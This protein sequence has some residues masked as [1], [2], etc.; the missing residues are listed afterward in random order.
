[1]TVVI[2]L[3]AKD[4]DKGV[5]LP[6]PFGIYNHLHSWAIL[7]PISV[8]ISLLP[9][10]LHL[11]KNFM[12]LSKHVFP[13][14]ENSLVFNQLLAAWVIALINKYFFLPFIT[15]PRLKESLSLKTKTFIPNTHYLVLSMV[16]LHLSINATCSFIIIN[17]LFTASFYAFDA[18][19]L[20]K[21]TF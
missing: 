3:K 13:S 12:E 18:S 16:K 2:S 5:S 10:Q 4:N 17:I 15:S 19:V 11:L 14:S 1:M 20:T 6:L 21:P 9:K 8:L 7:M